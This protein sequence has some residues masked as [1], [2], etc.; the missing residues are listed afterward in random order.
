MVKPNL[1]GVTEMRV[2]PTQSTNRGIKVSVVIHTGTIR[3]KAHFQRSFTIKQSSCAAGRS[4]PS[5]SHATCDYILVT[6]AAISLMNFEFHR[7]PKIA[8]GAMTR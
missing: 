4:W 8:R 3:K 5:T 2:R 6:S 1:S 7:E